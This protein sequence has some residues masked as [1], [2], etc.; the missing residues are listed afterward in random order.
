MFWHGMC[1]IN[2]QIFYKESMMNP[3]ATELAIIN[4]FIILVIFIDA[5]MKIGSIPSDNFDP[6]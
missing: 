3:T 5:I 4:S 6:S 1:L 2:G